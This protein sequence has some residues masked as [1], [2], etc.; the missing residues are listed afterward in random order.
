MSI[1]L[2]I[3][4]ICLST[5]VSF[6]ALAATTTKKTFDDVTISIL[7]DSIST[8]EN[9]SNGDAAKTTTPQ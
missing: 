5:S 4:I 8:F 2:A 7:G 6:S 9:Y 1:A 3:I